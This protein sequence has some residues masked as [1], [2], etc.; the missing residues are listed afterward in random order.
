MRMSRLK[1]VA[2]AVG[3][4]CLAGGSLSATTQ[5]SGSSPDLKNAV[6]VRPKVVSKDLSE[7]T[8]REIRLFAQSKD[9]PAVVE[10]WRDVRWASPDIKPE[11]VSAYAKVM[12]EVKECTI[13]SPAWSPDG[14]RIAF[15]TGADPYDDFPL[16]FADIPRTFADCAVWIVDVAGLGG[17]PKMALISNPIECVQQPIYPFW[18]SSGEIGWCATTPFFTIHLMYFPPRCKR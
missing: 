16:V 17:T 6:Y 8:A 5:K 9:L 15:T 4:I 13:H 3:L 10:R 18:I 11:L 1:W 7:V 12:S 2:L 14:K